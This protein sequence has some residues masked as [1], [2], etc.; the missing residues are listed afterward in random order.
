[1]KIAENLWQGHYGIYRG[2]DDIGQ[3]IGSFL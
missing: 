3:F 1:M 2:R